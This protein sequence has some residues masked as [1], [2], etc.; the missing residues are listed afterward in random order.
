MEDKLEKK[1]RYHSDLCDGLKILYRRKNT[2]YGD[3]FGKMI[4][5]RGYVYALDKM[6]EKLN[7]IE[8]LLVGGAAPQVDESVTDTLRYLANYAL[9]TLVEI[10]TKEQS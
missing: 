7:R 3:A 5:K 10:H 9:M 8:T 1:Y 6:Q 2:D 4:Q